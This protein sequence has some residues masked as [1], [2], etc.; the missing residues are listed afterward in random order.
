M[1][2]SVSETWFI[3]ALAAIATG[4]WRLTGL[5]LANLI[6]P[7]SWIMQLVNAIAHAMVAAVLILIMVYPTGALATTMLES[8]LICLTLGLGCMLIT[9]RL[10]LSLLI[11]LSSFAV[12]C[13]TY[14]DSFFAFYLF[15][16]SSSDIAERFWPC[17]FIA[18]LAL[19]SICLNPR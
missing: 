12:F 6:S 2:Y 8:R 15:V 14:I 5:L 7:E 17:E 10:W 1:S 4:G 19:T 16:I 9:R 18:R 11:S 13:L 3:I